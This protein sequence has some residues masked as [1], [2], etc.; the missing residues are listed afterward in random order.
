MKLSEITKIRNCYKWPI[1]FIAAVSIEEDELIVPTASD[2]ENSVEFVLSKLDEVERLAIIEFFKNE[3][4][5]YSIGKMFGC[6]S[7]KAA[8]F[9]LNTLRQIYDNIF[10]CLILENGLEYLFDN[11]LIPKQEFDSVLSFILD[12]PD[13]E[14]DNDLFDDDDEDEDD[15]AEIESDESIF[16]E[17]AVDISYLS[18]WYRNSVNPNDEPIWTDAHLEELL[19]DFYVIPKQK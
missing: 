2:I 12:C 18:D 7:Y 1:N 9:I 19:N 10:F 16:T 14:D 5:T 8:K 11:N 17:N 4:S 6:S 15:E 3:K 13:D